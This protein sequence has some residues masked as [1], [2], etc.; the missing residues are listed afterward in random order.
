MKMLKRL[1]Q[2][3]NKNKNE[4]TNKELKKRLRQKQESRTDNKECEIHEEGHEDELGYGDAVIRKIFER[5]RLVG[6]KLRK[7]WCE[8]TAEEIMNY[9]EVIGESEDEL[10]QL[11][12]L[13]EKEEGSDNT[14][15]SEDELCYS[16][17]EDNAIIEVAIAEVTD[18]EDLKKK[19]SLENSLEMNTSVEISTGEKTNTQLTHDNTTDIPRQRQSTDGWKTMSYTGNM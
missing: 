3:F 17:G 18:S 10:R 12:W 14:N 1:E 19:N 11:V 16:G 6:Q 8:V 13:I 5:K 9:G 15:E 2:K 4:D 7:I